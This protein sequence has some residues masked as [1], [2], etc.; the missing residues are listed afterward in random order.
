MFLSGIIKQIFLLYK[1]LFISL[2]VCI[3]IVMMFGFQDSGFEEEM[4]LDSSPLSPRPSACPPGAKRRGAS[5]P[6]KGDVENF[7]LSIIYRIIRKNFNKT[8]AGT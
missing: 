4:D 8:T 7:A 3:I 2:L 5:N 6:G 1:R